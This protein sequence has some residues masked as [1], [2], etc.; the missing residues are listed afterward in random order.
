[1]SQCR[2]CCQK[3][4]KRQTEVLNCSAH[5]SVKL[6]LLADTTSKIKFFD[7]HGKSRNVFSKPV[8]LN[9]NVQLPVVPVLF[10]DEMKFQAL[11]DSGSMR[12]LITTKCLNELKDAK[13]VKSEHKLKAQLTA[14]NGQTIA[15]RKTV[16]LHFKIHKYSW[17][18]DF[19]VVASLP[20]EV[21]LGY[22]IMKHTRMH[23]DSANER[24]FF[25]VFKKR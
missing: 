19:W 20:F 7:V 24:V 4:F 13:L 16:S 18:H 17:T 10:S 6:N 1:M 8:L 15:V 23:I 3:L 9:N 25:S 2:S 5:T 14:V 11:I 22:N 12:S 21:I